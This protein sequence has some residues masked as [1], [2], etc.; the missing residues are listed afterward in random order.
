MTPRPRPS[1]S[2]APRAARDDESP[3]HRPFARKHDAN[4]KRTAP[5]R[6]IVKPASA[7]KATRDGDVSR[8]LVARS[9]E[10]ARARRSNERKRI[11]VKRA[12]EDGEIEDVYDLTNAAAGDA[13]RGSGDD[14]TTREETDPHKLRQ[15]QRQIDYGKN[16][17]GYARYRELV[18]KS[19]RRSSDAWTPN[20]RAGMS[21]RAFDGA[22]RKWRRLLHAYDP[23]VEDDE[24]MVRV[25]VDPLARPNGTLKPGEYV[26]RE[27][28]EAAEARARAKAEA[29]A[30]ARDGRRLP[31][32]RLAPLRAANVA[33]RSTLP[34][35]ADMS[36]G[37][38]AVTPTPRKR[39]GFAPSSDAARATDATDA[40]DCDA[41]VPDLARRSIYDDWEGE[42]FVGVV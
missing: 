2:R 39:P 25:P 26:P 7:R 12:I 1:P 27:L 23:P 17:L 41:P 19:A 21:K 8:G 38:D 6:A 42:D 3:S 13:R 33:T 15:R 20:I 14:A 36:P 16:T 34:S 5:A 28:A 31:V 29:E 35:R 37:W 22:V 32:V 40:M 9:R 24:E 18:A 30:A 4:V 10:G 11:D